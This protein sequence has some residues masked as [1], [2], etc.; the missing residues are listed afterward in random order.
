MEYY[1]RHIIDYLPNKQLPRLVCKSWNRH[2][3]ENDKAVL[4]GIG[5]QLQLSN[6]DMKP[7]VVFEHAIKSHTKEYINKIFVCLSRPI[8]YRNWFSTLLHASERDD[9]LPIL[10]ELSLSSNDM[11]LRYV[12]LAIAIQTGNTELLQ[13]YLP[14]N[15]YQILSNIFRYVSKIHEFTLDMFRILDVRIGW[16]LFYINGGLYTDERLNTRYDPWK[17]LLPGAI[18]VGNDHIARSICTK[19]SRYLILDRMGYIYERVPKMRGKKGKYLGRI[20]P[21]VST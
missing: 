1:I 19:R 6:T 3:L 10:F 12:L 11:N 13:K 4:E 18:R 17:Q 20:I 2:L 9:M 15:S 7:D 16:Y 8:R 14:S 5:R 21:V